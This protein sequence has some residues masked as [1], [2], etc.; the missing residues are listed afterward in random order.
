MSSRL[1]NLVWL[2]TFETAARLQ[3]FTLAGKELGLTQTAVSLHIRSL[4][5]ALKRQLFVRQARHLQLTSEGEAYLLSVSQALGDIRAATTNLFGVEEQQ[6]ITVR[7]PISTAALWLAKHLPDFKTE[8]PNITVRLVS[9][10]WASSA[11]DEDIDVDLRLGRSDEYDGP[12]EVISSETVTAVASLQRLGKIRDA[13]DLEDQPRISI[14]GYDDCWTR[15]FAAAGLKQPTS[16][17]AYSVDTSMAALALVSANAGC[18][19]ILTRFARQ[20][21]LAHHQIG[22]IGDPVPFSHVHYIARPK[23]RRQQKP[24]SRLF[25]DWLKR[26]FSAEP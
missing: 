22:M 13:R 18:A 6:L 26:R 23:T 5:A 1:P 12:S 21:T 4:E 20:A 19:A 24:E 7:A 25:E 17:P 2:R 16:V 8:Y 10:I 14:L 3:N 9:T 11:V 15:C